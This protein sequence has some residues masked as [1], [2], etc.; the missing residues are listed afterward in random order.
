MIYYF[1]KYIVIQICRSHIFS[2]NWFILFVLEKKHHILWRLNTNETN[3]DKKEINIHGMIQKIPKINT[4]YSD[5]QTR[6]FC[7]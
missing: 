7:Q 2:T 5:L 4:A 6:P 3:D 1:I